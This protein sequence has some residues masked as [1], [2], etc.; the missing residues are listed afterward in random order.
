M[1][2]KYLLIIFII[3]SPLVRVIAQD[4]DTTFY[5]GDYSV[6]VDSIIITGNE[7]TDDFII[8]NEL[9]FHTGDEV[10]SKILSYNKERVYSLGI[11]T[12]VDIIPFHTNSINVIEIAVKESWYIFPIPFLTIKENDWNK[13]SY[14]LDLLIQ[15]FRGN[16]EKIR[17]RAAFGYD[18]NYLISYANPYISRANNIFLNLNLS[19]SEIKN[20]SDIASSLYGADFDQKISGIGIQIGK[21]IGLFQKLYINLGYN[22]VET[23]F[24]IKGISASESRIDHILTNGV[25]YIYDTRDLIQFARTGVYINTTFDFKGLNADNINYRVFSID[26]RNYIKLTQDLSIKGRIKSRLAMGGFVPYYDFSFFGYEDRIRGYYYDKR[27]GNYSY[28]TSLEMNYPL[29]KDFNIN[30]NFI[31]LLPKALFSY[32]VAIYAELF[33]D[34]G[35]TNLKGAAASIKNVDSGYGAGLT[36]LIL[37]YSVFRIE[38]AINDLGKQQWILGIGTSF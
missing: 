29:I 14:G 19:Y 26:F 15:N 22:L 1:L 20:K 21:R 10:D 23:P 25:G 16:N 33:A 18:P 7:K 30:L 5:S 17:L 37:P 11:F 13:L 32:R 34:A 2:K 9:T 27:E 31:P 35:L 4:N 3:F 36:F 6:K 12:H 8:L 24:Y 28:L 38:Y